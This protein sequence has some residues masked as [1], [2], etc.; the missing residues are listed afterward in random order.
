MVIRTTF[1]K[2]AEQADTSRSCCSNGMSVGSP[3]PVITARSAP[4]ARARSSQW[5]TASHGTRAGAWS[6]E[7]EAAE[8][9]NEQRAWQ[10]EATG[11]SDTERGRVS[12]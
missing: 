1:G 12:A 10:A 4:A 9:Q 11:R 8:K 2:A 3:P 5:A 6:L 7:I